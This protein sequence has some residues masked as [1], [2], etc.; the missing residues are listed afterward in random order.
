MSVTGREYFDSLGSKWD[1]MREEFFPEAVR[2]RSMEAVGVESG[3]VA[4]DVGAGTGFVTQG[5][6][7]RGLSVIAVDQSPVMLDALRLKYSSGGAIDCRQG[8]AERLPIEDA[9]ADYCFANMLL[10]HVEN[11]L[12]AIR[13]MARVVRPG[14][15]VVVTDLDAHEHQFLK[16]EHHDRWMGFA[17]QDIQQWL[18][19][20][21]L[22]SVQ[23]ESVGEE[24]RSMSCDGEAAAISIFLGV[25]TVPRI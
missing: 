13:E 7:A 4:V 1:E 22:V 20:A 21:G 8:D 9:G 2:E 23:I 18:L 3:R 25:G 6:V 17:R 24:C 14:G 5:L 10:H 12:Q 11:P 19:E 16:E 15:Q